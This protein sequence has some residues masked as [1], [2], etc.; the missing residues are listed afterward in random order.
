[1]NSY[2]TYRIYADFVNCKKAFDRVVVIGIQLVL[3]YKS[4]NW[5]VPVLHALLFAESFFT[6]LY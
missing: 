2:R 5:F 6:S 4:F 1:M 3:R